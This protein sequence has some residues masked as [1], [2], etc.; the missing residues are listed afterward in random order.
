MKKSSL[1]EILN[2][3]EFSLA[4]FEDNCQFQAIQSK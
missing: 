3:D 1:Y 2:T 4:T